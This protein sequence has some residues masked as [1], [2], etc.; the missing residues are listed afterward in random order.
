MEPSSTIVDLLLM[1]YLTLIQRPSTVIVS[2]DE[3]HY[4]IVKHHPIMILLIPQVRPAHKITH[5]P[6]GDD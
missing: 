2:L 5:L 4:V 1:K 3:E 6:L